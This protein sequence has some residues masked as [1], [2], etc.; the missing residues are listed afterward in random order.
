M[1][2]RCTVCTSNHPYA[3]TAAAIRAVVMA[4]PIPILRLVPDGAAWRVVVK[5]E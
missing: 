1:K 3:L 4:D 2:T 5:A